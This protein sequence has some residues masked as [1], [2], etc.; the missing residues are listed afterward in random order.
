MG[1]EKVGQIG[2]PVQDL[3]RASAFYQ[4]VLGLSLLF[5]TDRVAF[6]E[7][8]GLR[9]LLSLPEKDEFAHASSII[10]FQVEDLPAVYNE[11][12]TKGVSFPIEPHVAAKIEQTETW[13]AFFKD[14]EGNTLALI[15]EVQI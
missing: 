3:E 15:S 6:F 11:I 9:L 4:D 1:I 12:A 7:C 13:M 10:Y 8:G 5:R 14:T 2:V